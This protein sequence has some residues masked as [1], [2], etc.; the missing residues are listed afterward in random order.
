MS[1]AFT[2]DWLAAR[3]RYDVAAL[4]RETIALLEAWARRQAADRPLRVVDLGCGTGTGLRRALGWLAG[5]SVE[6]YGVDADRRLLA[7][8]SEAHAGSGP[9]AG[10]GG[11]AAVVEQRSGPVAGARARQVS[12]TPVLADVLAPLDRAGGPLDGTVDLVVAHAVAD[13]LPL[14]HF[15]ER[16]A[17]LLRPGGCA[18]I[19]L[20]YDG[21]M[22]FCPSDDPDLDSRVLDAYHRHMDR[23][24]ADRPTYGGSMAGRRLAGALTGAGLRVLRAAPSTWDVRAADGPVGRAVL[25]GLI[26]FVI[27][28]VSG[29]GDLAAGQLE[30]WEH[31]RRTALAAGELRTR[32]RHVDVLATRPDAPMV[33]SA[34]ASR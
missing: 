10:Q 22:A 27:G 25:D 2:P 19:A 34:V 4:D 15:A 17:A 33:H 18:H 7:R 29:L 32:V 28:S 14:D 6:A 3:D 8:L 20:T 26:G 9:M 11:D 1:D 12:V 31:A 13:L 21:D 23:A 24:R 30:R 5:R 16:V